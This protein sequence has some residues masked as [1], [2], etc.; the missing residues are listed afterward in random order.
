MTP[1]ATR[2]APRVRQSRIERIDPDA[3]YPGDP[4]VARILHKNWQSVLNDRNE[5]RPTPVATVIG[6]RLFY[7]GADI[8]AFLDSCREH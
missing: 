8:I 1:T 7:R 5:G 3:W 2:R 6:G 4:D